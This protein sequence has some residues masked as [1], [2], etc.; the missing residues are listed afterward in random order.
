MLRLSVSAAELIRASSP[1]GSSTW[2]PAVIL[3][4]CRHTDW[5]GRAAMSVETCAR[6]LIP[7]SP[8]T[9]HRYSVAN[10]E[11]VGLGDRVGVVVVDAQQPIAT[12]AF[13][14]QYVV[15]VHELPASDGG[16]RQDRVVSDDP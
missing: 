13:T 5:D 16:T 12:V 7:V 6:Y 1:G 10:V 15:G 8:Q 9:G 3:P 2:P 14:Q 4:A 11:N